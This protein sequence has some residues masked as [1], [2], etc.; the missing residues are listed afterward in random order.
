MTTPFW[1]RRRKSI[2]NPKSFSDKALNDVL[3]NDT[4][5]LEEYY[6]LIKQKDT[7]KW[8]DACSKELALLT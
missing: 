8:K 5:N 6:H 7:T 3:K 2:S 1:R 4:G